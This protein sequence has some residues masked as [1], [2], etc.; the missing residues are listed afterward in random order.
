MQREGGTQAPATRLSQLILY[1][2]RNFEQ[3]PI[4][5]TFQLGARSNVGCNKKK[6][7]SPVH[8]RPA[9]TPRRSREPHWIADDIR[10]RKT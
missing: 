5:I 7:F 2:N 9:H 4:N 1:I 8:L 10:K 3:T 6:W